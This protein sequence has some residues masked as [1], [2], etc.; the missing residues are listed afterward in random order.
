MTDKYAI[1]RAQGK[2][3]NVSPGKTFE[4]DRVAG[5]IGDSITFSEVLLI[6][7]GESVKVGAPFLTGVKITAKIVSQHRAKKV[8]IFKKTIKKGY[9]KRQGHRQDKSRLIV[10]EF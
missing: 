3:Y 1:I 4:L 10:G 2:Q 9:T 5:S 6:S 7:E 8:M